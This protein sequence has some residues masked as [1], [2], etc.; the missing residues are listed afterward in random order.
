M[1][2]EPVPLGTRWGGSV[3]TPQDSVVHQENGIQLRMRDYLTPSGTGTLAQYGDG[4]IDT[5]TSD[6]LIHHALRLDAVGAA[7]DFRATPP[8]RTAVSLRFVDHSPVENMSVD[9][10]DGPVYI[11]QILNWPTPQHGRT[12]K[13][14][15]KTDPTPWPI[16]GWVTI[17][18][19]VDWVRVG[20]AKDGS[21]D[22]GL[23]LDM[24]CYHLPQGSLQPP[25]PL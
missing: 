4:V 3:N 13:A 5:L 20:G 25:N 16:R 2:F 1:T 24:I 7:F 12:V 17:Y 10:P 18:G 11:G 21:P 8:G 9:D 15:P 19:N 23:W 6:I 22:G 14:V